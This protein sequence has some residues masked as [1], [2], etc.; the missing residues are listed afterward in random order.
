MYYVVFQYNFYTRHIMA[1]IEI[2]LFEQNIKCSQ[3]TY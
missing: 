1:E 2:L 3:N